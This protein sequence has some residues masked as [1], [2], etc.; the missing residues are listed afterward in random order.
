MSSLSRWSL[1]AGFLDLLLVI[2]GA[3]ALVY[4]PGKFV[5]RGDAAAT[6]ANIAAHETLF[7]FGIVD[8][9]LS[10]CVMLFT[11]FALYMLLKDVNKTQ[12]TLM[13]I[14]GGVLN[15]A[16][17]F[18][19]VLTNAATLLLARPEPYLE[20]LTRQQRGAL[21]MFFVNLGDQGTHAAQIMWGLWLFPLAYLVYRSR[22]L[23]RFIGIWLVVN[24][25][26]YIAQSLIGFLAPS[27][28]GRLG[29]V[30]MVAQL[31]EVAL[32]IAL[33]VIGVRSL[34]QQQ[35]TVGA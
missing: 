30:F 11:T 3:I 21:L 5:V 28:L 8:N 1:T 19:Y 15:T 18:A 24:G 26:A 29:S 4:I 32:M 14:L 20:P 13:V 2:S 7:R 34:T 10:S 16:L 31:G 27:S 17:G 6:A 9:L 23:P 25:I 33:L 22:F 35:Q 12:A